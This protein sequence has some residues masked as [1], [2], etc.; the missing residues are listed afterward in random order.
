MAG[1]AGD[2]LKEQTM[3]VSS[4]VH[5]FARSAGLILVL[6]GPF[7]AC[8]SDTGS[9]DSLDQSASD[10]KGGAPSDKSKGKGKD[11]GEVA[12]GPAVVEDA[13]VVDGKGNGKGQGQDKAKKDK[14]VKT[15]G[16][17][18]GEGAAGGDA[19]EAADEQM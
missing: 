19:D 4:R 3:K 1:S 12:G 7:A 11:K 9:G 10:L 18:A 14:A 13:G 17:S 5:Q 8:A 6:A 16:K 15:H 2:H